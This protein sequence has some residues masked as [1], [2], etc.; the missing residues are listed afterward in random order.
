MARLNSAQWR[1]VRNFTKGGQ[2]E[3][4]GV[5]IHIMAGTLMG[6]EAWFDNPAARASSHFGT[7][8]DGRLFQ[9]V[10]TANKAWAQANGNSSWLSVENEGQGGDSLT[11]AQL[12]RCADVLRWAH[13]VYGVPLQVATSPSGRGLG[14][15]AMGGAAWGGHTSCPGSKIVAQLPEIVK[16]AGG[17]AASTAPTAGSGVSRATVTI[18]GLK[19]GYGVNGAH[20]TAV[21]K[22]L[23]AAG[24][25]AYV[26]GPGPT[27]TDADTKSYAK[28]QRKCGYTGSDADG[29]P[30][31]ASLKKLMGKLPSAPAAAK[32]AAPVVD[33]SNLVAAARRDPGLKQ[34]GTTHAADVKVVE[35]AL[36]AEGLLAAKYAADGS[37]G[38]VTVTAYAAWQRKCGYTGSAADGIPG[39]ASLE[40]L[41]AKRGFKVKA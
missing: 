38:S 22:A 40:K 4:R 37:F 3:V 34:G 33:L 7:G 10:D 18:G 26:E 31:E 21:G 25:S 9:W 30:G 2:A 41:G 23:V 27:W 15:H 20:V 14:Y 19:Y 5:V 11:D 8:K 12:D 16:R 36:K 39:K 24:C 17:K 13:E 29:V 35:A 32:P 6:S 1:P 28:W